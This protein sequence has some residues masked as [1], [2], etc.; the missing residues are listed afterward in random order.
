MPPFYLPWICYT[1]GIIVIIVHFILEG[2][3]RTVTETVPSTIISK[4][5]NNE[6]H[7][8]NDT[9]NII[10]TH[11]LPDAHFNVWLI[12]FTVAMSFSLIYFGYLYCWRRRYHLR[13]VLPEVQQQ[14]IVAFSR[15]RENGENV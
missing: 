12:L 4:I 7:G 14:F 8:I 3:G 13:R 15:R 2:I 1:K 11:G 6:T 5:Q 10:K 9:D